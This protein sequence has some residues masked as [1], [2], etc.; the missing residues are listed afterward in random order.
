MNHNAENKL[1]PGWVLAELSAIAVLNP[2]TF[3]NPP[4]DEEEVSFVPMAAV[5]AESGRLDAS[6]TKPWRAVNKGYTR[7]QEGDVLFA[8]ITPC[9]ENGKFALATGLVG[10]R[11][12]GSTEFHVLRP[13][14]GVNPKLLLFFLLRDCSREDERSGGPAARSARIPCPTRFS[15]TP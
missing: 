6:T 13:L 8:N 12:A 7:F 2:R 9:M 14:Q 11:A 1:P 3:D 4:A 10:G 15:A 5:E